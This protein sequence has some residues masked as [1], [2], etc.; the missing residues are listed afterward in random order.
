MQEGQGGN[1]MGKLDEAKDILRSI[2]M[3][4]QQCN[5]RSAYVLLAICHIEE[6][7]AWSSAKG[8]FIGITEIMGSMEFNYSITYKPNTRETVRKDSVH[9]FRDA[10]I[11]EDNGLATNSPNYRYKLT[12]EMQSLVAAYDSPNWDRELRK[13][14]DGKETLSEKYRQRRRSGRIPVNINDAVLE[15]SP[16]A[17]NQLQ[18]RIIEDFAPVFAPGAVVLY[19]GDAEKK[20]LVK[21]TETLRKLRVEMTDHDK[22][23]DVILYLEERNWLFFIEAAVSVGPMSKKR[24][25]EISSMT[26]GSKCGKIFVTAFPDRKT[27]RSHADELAWETEVW[28]A[29]IPDH[30]IHLDGERFLGPY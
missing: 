5:D 3:P 13:F 10:G 6:S 7:D 20:D 18:K 9:Q 27:F 11:I 1:D 22:L 23:P 29:D 30:M 24:V 16:G 14:L 26:S 15:F 8:E 17:H 19:V 21:D 4:E 12:Q 2:G 28:I 25:D